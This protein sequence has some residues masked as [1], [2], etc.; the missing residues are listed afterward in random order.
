MNELLE[1]CESLEGYSSDDLG[2]N[3]LDAEKC[4]ESWK[5]RVEKYSKGLE[6][7]SQQDDRTFI[8]LAERLYNKYSTD[9]KHYEIITCLKLDKD[10]W[11]IT[12]QELKDEKS[13]CKEGE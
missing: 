4:N 3:V 1:I 10:K 7:P 12:I 8:I 13:N 5:L 6:N 11:C 2:F 9:R